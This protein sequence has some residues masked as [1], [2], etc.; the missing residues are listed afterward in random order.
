MGLV[1]RV[2]SGFASKRL[3]PLTDSFKNSI[4]SH[5]SALVPLKNS[6]SGT[7]PTQPS[8]NPKTLNPV[9]VLSSVRTQ[10]G[11]TPGSEF[12]RGRIV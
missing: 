6:R 2:S 7:L 4:Q 8:L 11:L 10:E 12:R 5:G 1:L 9:V 3:R